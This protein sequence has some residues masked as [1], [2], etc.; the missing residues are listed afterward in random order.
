V[1]VVYASLSEAH[2][3]TRVVALTREE[4][5][6]AVAQLG[7]QYQVRGTPQE[8]AQE[9]LQA[10]PEEELL[11]EV[12]RDR[13]LTL[14][15]LNDKG[16]LVPE[17]EAALKAEYLRWCQPRGGGDCLG[18]FTD[19]S[20]LRTDDRRTL[21]LALAFGPVLDETRAALGRELS[22]Q[23]LLSSLVWAAGL[24]LALWLL[25]E[26]STKAVAAALSV[27]LLAWLGLDAMWGL[28][29]G[30]PWRT[31]PMRPPRS[32][33]CAMRARPSAGG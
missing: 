21:A 28:M 27:V 29:D 18:L 12:Y 32:R 6:R 22:P 2:G 23:V 10:M 11:A 33:S 5:R 16:P 4:Y 20:Y 31:G 24:Y 15:P 19:G 3:K 8:T 30:P 25:P 26:P 17:A 13:V 7:Q 9:L 1:V 14:V